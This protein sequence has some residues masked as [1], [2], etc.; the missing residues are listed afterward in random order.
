MFAGAASG[1]GALDVARQADDAYAARRWPEA[2]D[3]YRRLVTRSDASW[4]TWYRLGMS[5]LPIA[6]ARAIP[7]FARS[8]HLGPPGAR[9][10]AFERLGQ[11]YGDVG[12][13][14]SAYAALDSAL[15]QGDRLRGLATDTAFAALR[16]DAGFAAF[17]AHADSVSRPCAYRS[18]A[19][20]LDFWLG[21]WVVRT[22]GGMQVG[23]SHEELALDA[24]VLVE[25]WS[26]VSGSTGRS[27]N[28][29]NR[30]SGH[31]EQTWFDDQGGTI[32]FRDGVASAGQVQF[33][34]KVRE[35]DG[36]P[37]ERR[38]TFTLLPDHRVRQFSERSTD[39]GKT[40]GVEYD[41]Y[42]EHAA[43]TSQ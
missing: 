31:W 27:I 4:Y 18:E 14:D 33:L 25:N 23:T 30:T 29:F 28:A 35:T 1:Q 19:R 40:W 21:D 32:E 20:S 42:Y 38:L 16:R 12:R 13:A 17:A 36:R 7:A 11:A 3:L 9:A 8:A 2:A 22:R 43:A 6:V 24:C 34:A 5:E 39:G 10:S 37:S 26:S 15:A 41:F